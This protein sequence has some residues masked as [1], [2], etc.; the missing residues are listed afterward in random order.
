MQGSLLR[1]G[2]REDSKGGHKM[3]RRYQLAE[4]R[5]AETTDEMSPV[6]VYINPDEAERRFLINTLR[7]DEHTLSSALDP[8][9]LSRLEFEPDHIAVV[10]KRPKYYSGE[11]NFL[12]KVASTGAFLF[13]DRLVV[14]LS[15]DAP[16]FDGK[17]FLKQHTVADVFLKIVY[18]SIFHFLEHLKVINLVSDRL[19]QK[20]NSAMENRYLLSLFALEKSLV[21]Y[22]NA[23]NSNG[24]LI[25]KL[26]ANSGKV[27]LSPEEIEFLDDM[28]IENSQCYRL[29]E[30][31]SNILASLMD[32]RASI[33]GNN[34][35]VLIKRLTILSVVFMPL[36]IIAGIGG[37]S[38]F[39]MM[40]QGIDWRLS[41]TLFSVALV[42]IGFV[43]YLIL[44]NF[45]L[46]KPPK[47]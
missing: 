32:A 12:F 3:L 39:S 28:M 14:V 41:Y 18:R 40:T 13:K 36:N 17:C 30:I 1:D 11:D 42:G 27:G 20:I 26:K 23:I 7:L 46:E 5:L 33:V 37:M 9:E 2:D 31:Y 35:N 22:L 38:E 25:E 19:E 24:V 47:E 6:L 16:M 43:T 44:R 4:G 21:Y 34:L 45:G 15:E 29:A 10:F 8:D